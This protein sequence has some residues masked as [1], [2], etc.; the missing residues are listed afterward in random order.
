MLAQWGG[1]VPSDWNYGSLSKIDGRR[2]ESES[3]RLRSAC[4]WVLAFRPAFEWKRCDNASVSGCPPPFSPKPTV[5]S[6]EKAAGLTRRQVPLGEV[7][8]QP[9]ESIWTWLCGG[10][11]G[12]TV[13]SENKCPSDCFPQPA[14][15][16][17]ALSFCCV[18]TKTKRK[19]RKQKVLMRRSVFS[20]NGRQ[21][22]LRVQGRGGRRGARGRLTSPAAARTSR[23]R[24][25]RRS[26]SRP[27]RDNDVAL[28]PG[29]KKNPLSVCKS[30]KCGDKSKSKRKVWRSLWDEVVGCERKKS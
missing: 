18:T 7:I 20:S 1:S 28:S 23:W 8:L 2:G 27:G 13:L 22:G 24:L 15:L 6:E 10:L 21:L 16:S 25:E 14:F 3:Q 12:N 9:L 17:Q 30:T 4:T 26:L 11:M 29:Q 19:L 5:E